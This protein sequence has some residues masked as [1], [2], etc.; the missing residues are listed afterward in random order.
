M[1]RATY[2]NW[3]WALGMLAFP[4]CWIYSVVRFGLFVGIGLGWFPSLVIAVLV[5]LAWPLIPLSAATLALAFL[6]R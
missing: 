2:S 6:L 5:G 3:A 4:C 1:T